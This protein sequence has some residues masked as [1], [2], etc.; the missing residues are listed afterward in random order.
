MF[1]G[2]P[3][4]QAVLERCGCVLFT[5]RGPR[6]TGVG[7]H[8]NPDLAQGVVRHILSSCVLRRR[9]Q[10]SHQGVGVSYVPILSHTAPAV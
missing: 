1:H 9:L 5:Q 8:R 3:S 10:Y 4:R 6:L 2:F 7:R